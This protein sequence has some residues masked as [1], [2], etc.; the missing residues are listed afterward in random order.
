MEWTNTEKA[1]A[2]ARTEE[3]DG[4]ALSLIDNLAMQARALRMN[5][6]V[7]MWQLARV[8]IEAKELIPHGAFG[9]WVEENADVSERT[10]QDMMA[11]YKRFGGMPQF[12]GLGQA[13]TF[14]LLPL[15]VEMEE[16]FLQEHDV[17][18]M[19]TRQVQEAV[20]KAREEA[21]K[22]IEQER[23][24]RE[25]AERRVAAANRDRDSEIDSLIE[26]LSDS[27]ETI[28]RQTEE[29]KQMAS[30][31]NEALAEQRRLRIEN[32][33]LQREIDERDEMLKEQQEDINR[34]QQELLNVQSTIA[35]GD[36]ERTPKDNLSTE[37][38]SHAV[39]TF[40]GTCARMP[41]MR[42]AFSA[43]TEE[44][45]EEYSILLKTV[46]KWAEDSRKALDAVTTD[47]TVTN[48]V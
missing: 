38:F 2:E 9:K 45:R 6:N 37:T 11:A 30:V 12:E 20:R 42:R 8:F 19:T 7:S 3:G 41:H 34:A 36:A 15:P 44:E 39:R 16:R 5:I 28:A 47:G 14:K 40:V 31:N 43:M 13:K 25:E 29:V 1:D 33:A 48:D 18:E 26:E 27:K 4:K 24:A 35:K 21:R 46:E 22:E 32:I 17:R 10:A 23:R